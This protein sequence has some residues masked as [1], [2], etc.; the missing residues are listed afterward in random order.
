LSVCIHPSHGRGVTS[1]TP[2]L[3]R[4]DDP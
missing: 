1:E 3:S 4:E 2:V